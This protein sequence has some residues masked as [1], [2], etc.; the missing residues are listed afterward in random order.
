MFINPK[1]HSAAEDM[2]WYVRCCIVLTRKSPLWEYNY[3]GNKKVI[4]FHQRLQQ[5]LDSCHKHVK[6]LLDYARSFQTFSSHQTHEP[7]QDPSNPF[8]GKST[9][10]GLLRSWKSRGIQSVFTVWSR[11]EVGRFIKDLNFWC[12][13]R[14][15]LSG[16]LLVGL[17]TAFLSFGTHMSMIRDE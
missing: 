2:I 16:P 4:K 5:R 13:S 17:Y 1:Y 6:T 15:E 9:L 14:V 7:S 10:E 8:F 11:F 12:S 3:R